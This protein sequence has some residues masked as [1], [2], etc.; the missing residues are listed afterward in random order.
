MNYLKRSTNQYE[1]FTGRSQ[2]LP[3]PPPS[4]EKGSGNEVV[5]RV[6]KRNNV[7]G[8]ERDTAGKLSRWEEVLRQINAGDVTMMRYFCKQIQDPSLAAAVSHQVVQ[9]DDAWATVRWK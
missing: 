7:V 6:I 5:A 9:H 8:I 3:A 1:G 4:K 2:G